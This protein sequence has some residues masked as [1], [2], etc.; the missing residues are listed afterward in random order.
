MKKK[1][2]KQSPDFGHSHNP[3]CPTSWI[4]AIQMVNPTTKGNDAY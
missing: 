4:Q 3:T 1:K 2:K